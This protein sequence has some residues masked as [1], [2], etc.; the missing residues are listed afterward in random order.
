[1]R[2]KIGKNK[3]VGMIFVAIMMAAICI[4][5]GKHTSFAENTAVLN[6]SINVDDE[7]Y[8]IPDET[9][10][11]VFIYL[12]D[13]EGN[14]I[15]G[16]FSY[17]G[18]ESGT[19]TFTEGKA[20]LI[21][22][23]ASSS[24]KF[25]NLPEN[26]KY[27][28]ELK[29][30]GCWYNEKTSSGKEGTLGAEEKTASITCTV[31]T[32]DQKVIAIIDTIEQLPWTAGNGIYYNDTYGKIPQPKEDVIYY[33]GAREVKSLDVL[34]SDRGGLT[35]KSKV[36]LADKE[37]AVLHNLP[38]NRKF[39]LLQRADSALNN[40][41]NSFWGNEGYVI[42]GENDTETRDKLMWAGTS[43]VCG[44]YVIMRVGE[45]ECTDYYLAK[46]Y[47]RQDENGNIINEKLDF[48]GGEKD[49][50]HNIK[51]KATYKSI[52]GEEHNFPLSNF[53]CP[54]TI[55][56]IGS[57][58]APEE[59]TITF[60]ENGIAN[61]EI[62]ANQIC[63]L[64][65]NS[66][67]GDFV[68][69]DAS[70][71]VIIDENGNINIDDRFYASHDRGLGLP[72]RP[73]GTIIEIEEDTENDEYTSITYSDRDIINFMNEQGEGE[74]SRYLQ[75]YIGDNWDDFKIIFQ[76]INKSTCIINMRNFTGELE[77]K[78][79]FEGE[80][81]PDR[82]FTFRIKFEDDA[83]DLKDFYMN[84][85]YLDYGDRKVHLELDEN[86][87][88][89]FKLKAGDK[90]N[91]VSDCEKLQ[92]GLPVGA[93]YTITED[94]GEDYKTEATNAVGKVKDGV[95]TVT[96]N[97]STATVENPIGKPEEEK[98]EVQ[99]EKKAAMPRTGDIISISCAVLILSICVL[100]NVISRKMKK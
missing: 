39:N 61:L 82:E 35:I 68:S 59:G 15:E 73:G 92:K 44:E 30:Y 64:G 4:F 89:T 3:L 52:L 25:E 75:K 23:G 54:Y 8:D 12:N 19:I 20:E 18:D 36:V 14:P 49:K 51:I 63:T 60:N 46:L 96:F 80:N 34:T 27:K 22:H 99:E 48:D 76:N 50:K 84:N 26:A 41:H 56:T 43:G 21:L 98:E 90:V 62:K 55:K 87:E 9:E 81:D 70:N 66:R 88:G 37:V 10:C 32:M 7:R 94:P 2:R 38:Y 31:N 91:I 5:A 74:N 11:N 77:V 42:P 69:R 58:E 24:V 53:T 86:Y 13:A 47:A 17:T 67:Y 100:G 95:I 85:I 6:V 93:R 16:D 57:D 45:K 83:S 33:T 65:K 40:E 97:N 1:M 71:Y 28:I 72:G 79:E 29:K 78:K